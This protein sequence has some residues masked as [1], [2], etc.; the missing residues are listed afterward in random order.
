MKVLV[1]LIILNS[2]RLTINEVVSKAEICFG[3]FK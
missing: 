3:K 2:K 1:I